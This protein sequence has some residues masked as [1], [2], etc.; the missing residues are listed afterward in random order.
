MVKLSKAKAI[1]FCLIVF[2]PG[3]K[4]TEGNRE[5][6][7]TERSENRFFNF[8]FGPCGVF[9]YLSTIPRFI[10]L[11]RTRRR[12][13]LLKKHPNTISCSTIPISWTKL[14]P[15]SQIYYNCTFWWNFGISLF[16]IT[17][18]FCSN[19]G[20]F[21]RYSWSEKNPLDYNRRP[22]IELLDLGFIW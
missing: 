3:C 5:F 19:L 12:I 21:I 16:F 4:E 18:Y 13:L 11:L 15:R 22:C 14:T 6:E 9:H 1:F 10:G 8:V 2:Y 20:E 17:V 7:K